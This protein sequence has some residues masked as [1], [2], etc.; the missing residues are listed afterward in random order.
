MPFVDGEISQ[1]LEPP[2]RIS[3]CL[4]SET[5]EPDCNTNCNANPDPGLKP[6]PDRWVRKKGI[7]IHRLPIS[8]YLLMSDSPLRAPLL[9]LVVVFGLRRVQ[10]NKQVYGRSYRQIE[11]QTAGWTGKWIGQFMVD[12]YTTG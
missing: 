3:G 7:P 10:V 2:N 5:F 9:L 12:G 6:T 8:P 1:G 4:P 11:I